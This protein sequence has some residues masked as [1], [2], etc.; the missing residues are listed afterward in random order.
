VIDKPPSSISLP[1]PVKRPVAAVQTSGD[2]FDVNTMATVEPELVSVADADVTVMVP[3]NGPTA[4]RGTDTVCA[5]VLAVNDVE[6]DIVI[7][8]A[9]EELIVNV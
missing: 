1:P 8:G 4:V 5:V 2:G 6:L 9:E 7:L 3:V